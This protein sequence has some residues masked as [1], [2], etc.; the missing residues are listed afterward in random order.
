MK[1]VLVCTL[2][3]LLV[4]PLA[5]MGSTTGA[6]MFSTIVALG[7]SLTD[8]GINPELG[9]EHGLQY[10]TDG[11]VWVEMLSGTMGTTLFDVA[12]GG[13]TTGTNNPAAA[14][15]GFGHTGLLWQA[16]NAIPDCLDGADTL[17][18]V[19][20]GANDFFQGRGVDQAVTNIVT[21]LTTLSAGGPTNILVLNLPDLG[22][23]PGFYD[24]DNPMVPKVATGWSLAFNDLLFDALQTFAAGQRA[25]DLYFLD[26]NSLFTDMIL[27]D[28]GEINEVFWELMFW[29]D[30]HPTAFG[31]SIVAGA[32]YEVLQGG[33]MVVPLPAAFWLLGTGL[34]G[35]FCIRRRTK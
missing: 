9:D 4:L 32:A 2:V 21:S 7:D 31:H 28:S 20:A 1:R 19:W 18:T 3:L 13:A 14:A 23:T 10:F 33:P 5:A 15:I 11:R 29:D 12:Y 34:A 30:V 6:S 25:V 35:V 16:D 24:D 26:I 27:M 8:N 17:F 22:L